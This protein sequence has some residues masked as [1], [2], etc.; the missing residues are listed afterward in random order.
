MPPEMKPV[1]TPVIK[2]SAALSSAASPAPS[3]L[4]VSIR[5]S[6]APVTAPVAAPTVE[7][8]TA[9]FKAP[10]VKHPIGPAAVPPVAARKHENLCAKLRSAVCTA[11]FSSKGETN[12]YQPP[13]H[14]LSL[15]LELKV[16][17]IVVRGV[18]T[19][20]QIP[21]HPIQENIAGGYIFCEAIVDCG[22]R[23]FR[24]WLQTLK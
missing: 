2:P 14:R 22:L 13:H 11:T 12:S 17:A 16:H 19:V 8:T 6:T 5:C 1:I 3:Q 10:A 24:I 15:Q 20:D 7:P 4:P 23:W 9:P 18:V 21:L